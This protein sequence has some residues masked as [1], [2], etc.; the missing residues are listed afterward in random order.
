MTIFEIERKKQHSE[1]EVTAEKA[2]REVGIWNLSPWPKLNDMVH[3]SYWLKD[4]KD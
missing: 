3:Q 1:L 4:K 2:H